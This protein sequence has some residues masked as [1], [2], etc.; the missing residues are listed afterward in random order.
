[1]RPAGRRARP[2]VR[3][4]QRLFF[5]FTEPSE[6]GVK[7][8]S[9]AV[10]RARLVGGK[11]VEVKTIFGHRPNVVIQAHCGSR[12]AFDRECDSQTPSFL[13][14]G[15]PGHGMSTDVKRSLKVATDC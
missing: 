10:A 9:T 1:M 4:H 3:Q 6:G 8:N 2:A 13:A 5:T 11:L 7:G 12:I 15:P 14:N